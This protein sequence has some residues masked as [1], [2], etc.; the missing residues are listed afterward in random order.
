[1]RIAGGGEGESRAMSLQTEISGRNRSAQPQKVGTSIKG[2]H[3]GRAAQKVGTSDFE[4][5]VGTSAQVGTS[6]K[7]A[8]RRRAN[9]F[10]ENPMSASVTHAGRGGELAGCAVLYCMRR[11]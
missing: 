1:M 3:V 4:K 11:Y 8:R 9:L 7:L 6:K 2:W 10:C 5:K